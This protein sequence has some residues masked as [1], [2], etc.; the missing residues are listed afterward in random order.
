MS[1]E[2]ENSAI[3]TSIEALAVKARQAAD[4]A[5]AMHYSQAAL[6]MAQVRVALDTEPP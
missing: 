1:K 4:G 2:T 6:N 3:N 5:Q